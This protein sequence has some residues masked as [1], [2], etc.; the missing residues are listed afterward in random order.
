[1]AA[2]P[3]HTASPAGLDGD[4]LLRA[5]LREDLGT[6]GDITTALSLGGRGPSA[7]GAVRAKA[8]GVVS[9]VAL[10]SRVFTL[11]DEACTVE[12]HRADGAAVSPGDLVLEVRGAAASLLEG[13]R[14]ALNVLQRLSGVAS[15]TARFVQAVAGTAAAIVDTRKTTPLWRAAE[16]AAVVHGGGRNHRFA[17]YDHVLL[18]ENHF[19]AAGGS[20]GE[21]TARVCAE[22]PAD[23]SVMAEAES[24]AQARELADAGAQVILLDNFDIADLTAA[25]A[26]LADHPRRAAF[27]LEA[28]GGI[29][30][31]HAGEVAATGVDRISVGALTHSAP[32][33]DL[34]MLIELGAD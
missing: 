19:A 9:G 24:L 34:S 10:A 31:E 14:T 16:K 27:E 17:L 5:A 32:A 22:A 12:V 23:V 21:V 11:V 29:G 8:H 33:L 7:Y 25:V 30:L 15:L 13:E 18:K 1:M 20:L 26:A 3:A 2:D 6:R 28:T 4:A